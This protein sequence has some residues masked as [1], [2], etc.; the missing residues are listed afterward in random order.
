LPACRGVGGDH[1]EDQR[2]DRQRQHEHGQQQA[3]AA[4]RDG[5]R[6]ADHAGERQRRRA[7]EQR[8]HH[9]GGCRTVE[10][11]HQPEDRCSDDQWNAGRNPVRQRL[12]DT[13]QLQRRPAHDDQVERAV[14]MVGGEQAVERQKACQH[15]AEPED[16]GADALQQRNVRPDRERHQHDDAEKEQDADQRAAADA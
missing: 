15:R 16:R 5:E 3:T 14:L 7:G 1:A 9:A 11:E 4:E 12:G 2:R 8:Q 10:V 6:G 13:R